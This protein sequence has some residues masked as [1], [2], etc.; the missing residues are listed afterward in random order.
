VSLPLGWNLNRCKL[1]FILLVAGSY[2]SMEG[3]P[4]EW[5][6]KTIMRE[7]IEELGEKLETTEKD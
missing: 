6:E 1:S 7:K 3:L 5:L 4:V 2:Y